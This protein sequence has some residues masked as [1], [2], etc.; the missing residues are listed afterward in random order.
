MTTLSRQPRWY[1]R[2]QKIRSRRVVTRG[3]P[4]VSRHALRAAKSFPCPRR[5]R[6]SR[7]SDVA[8]IEVQTLCDDSVRSVFAE[9]GI[10]LGSFRGLALS[11]GVG[12]VGIAPKPVGNDP[13]APRRVESV[14]ELRSA[15][16]PAENEFQAVSPK[17]LLVD[18]SLA[19]RSAPEPYGA[20]S[21][22]GVEPIID[23]ARRTDNSQ[24]KAV[25]FHRWP[26]LGA[27]LIHNG[28]MSERDLEA[29]LLRQRISNQQQISG[30][31]LG[32]LLVT[33]GL[34]TPAQ[35]ARLLAE[36]YELPFVEL[37]GSEIHL[38]P[39]TLLSEELARRFSAVPISRF[40]DNSVL[41]ALADPRSVFFSD[42]LHR[43]LGAPLRFA[44]AAPEKV[45]AAITVAYQRA[46]A[47]T[48]R[49]RTDTSSGV[50][51]HSEEEETPG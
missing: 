21:N 45:D 7:F 50:R 30:K 33:H 46:P 15:S 31:R 23:T 38:Q 10:F 1:R 34:V 4:G 44:V 29:V 13:A 11:N 5:R 2:A 14:V 32:E 51:V 24:K 8:E 6:L 48:G 17:L 18:P 26:A 20:G 43:A 25:P 12:S 16:G 41:V 9:E 35:V 22:D 39:A 19:P 37:D 28:L 47:L 49:G 27:L 40:S 36:Q 3:N 42:D